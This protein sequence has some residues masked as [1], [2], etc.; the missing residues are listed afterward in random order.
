MP[1]TLADLAARV[2]IRQQ[3]PL[4]ARVAQQGPFLS[5]PLPCVLAV[6]QEPFQLVAPL[7]AKCVPREPFRPQALPRVQRVQ[8]GVPPTL[9]FLAKH[10]PRVPIVRQACRALRV[11]PTTDALLP[12]LAV[13]A[14]QDPLWPKIHPPCVQIA[15]QA[16]ISLRPSVCR[17][18][19]AKSPT[20]ALP[21]AVCAQQAPMRQG[22]LLAPIVPLAISKQTPRWPFVKRVPRASIRGLPP[23]APIVPRASLQ[24]MMLN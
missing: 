7:L 1:T 17:V 21:R 14:A 12:R 2:H 24:P 6:Q 8:Q 22:Y 9:P 23:V 11:P 13:F 15:Q 20:R 10:V 18:D 3:G 19:Q 4:V 16:R 5:K